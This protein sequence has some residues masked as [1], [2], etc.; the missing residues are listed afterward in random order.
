MSEIKPVYQVKR[1]DETGWADVTQESYKNCEL[2]QTILETRILYP[3]ADYEV[4]RKENEALIQK[5]ETAAF[6]HFAAQERIEA[7]AKRIAELEEHVTKLGSGSRQHLYQAF[8]RRYKEILSLRRENEALK[9][10][11]ERLNG[12]YHAEVSK[13][14]LDYNAL[15]AEN[16]RLRQESANYENASKITNNWNLEIA[17]ANGNLRQKNEALQAKID[18]L[19]LEYCPDEMTPEQIENYAAHQVKVVI[20]NP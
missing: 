20:C 19:M 16:E 1:F 14:Q 4:L 9:E 13:H 7:Q 12:L 11:L 15:K 5:L 3:A 10:K 8:A 17:N 18:S 2:A 6:N